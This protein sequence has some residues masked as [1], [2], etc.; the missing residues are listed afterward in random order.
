M[1]VLPI[2][3][4][5]I[6]NWCSTS[7]RDSIQRYCRFALEMSVPK[8]VSVILKFHI[9]NNK[10]SSLLLSKNDILNY[11]KSY[12]S[13]V[14]F[15]HNFIFTQSFSDFVSFLLLIIVIGDGSTWICTAPVRQ[16][17]KCETLSIV[18]FLFLLRVNRQLLWKAS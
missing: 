2:W 17:F 7:P 11:Y 10:S 16:I 18:G 8:A 14:G 9:N 12:F 5:K 6:I 1:F 3:A 13:D 15:P 4:H